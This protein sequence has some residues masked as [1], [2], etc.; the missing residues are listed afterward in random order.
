[1]RHPALF[2]PLLSSLPGPS[3]YN[4]PAV[5]QSNPPLRPAPPQHHRHSMRRRQRILTPSSPA[6]R[7]TPARA[8]LQ[9]RTPPS[10]SGRQTGST[11]EA[12]LACPAPRC[13]CAGARM[14]FARPQRARGG[15]GPR[16]SLSLSQTSAVSLPEARREGLERPPSMRAR[17]P[18]PLALPARH[19]TSE[20]VGDPRRPPP[21][22]RRQPRPE[23]W[24]ASPET[25]GPRC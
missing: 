5:P 6:G 21:L 17:R 18:K 16:Q 23:H 15:R 1:M 4:G 22:A 14:G 9:P 24:T 7:E 3:L 13:V 10:P 12:P 2:L 25:D 20:T 19:L 11:R 8:A